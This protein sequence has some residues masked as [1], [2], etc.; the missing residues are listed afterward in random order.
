MEGIGIALDVAGD[1]MFMTDL[2]G[3]VYTARLDG[4]EKRA[5]IGAAGNLTGICFAKTPNQEK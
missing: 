2:A 3:S 5:L 4:S 1:R